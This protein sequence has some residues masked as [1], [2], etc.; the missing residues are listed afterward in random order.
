MPDD[1]LYQEVVQIT[2]GTSAHSHIND[3][4]IMSCSEEGMVNL[5]RSVTG[6]FPGALVNFLVLEKSAFYFH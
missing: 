5:N 4:Q 2:V 3:T 1:S 6:V